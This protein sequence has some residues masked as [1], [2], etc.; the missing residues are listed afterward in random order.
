MI[1]LHQFP[2]AF[3]LINASP[4]CL[5]LE[6]W[7]RLTGLEYRTVPLRDPGEGPKGRAPYIEDG[8][9]RIG[10]SALIIEHLKRS[11]GLD[12]DGRL[13]PTE[14]GIGRAVSLMLEDHL[15][16]II[17]HERW[18]ESC[19][20]PHVRDAFLRGLPDDEAFAIQN[21]IRRRIRGQGLGLHTREERV[22]LGI[23][24][25]EA[26]SEILGSK[27]FLL[28][29]EATTADCTAFAMMHNLL[30]PTFDNPVRDAALGLANIVAYEHR[31][32]QR[33]FPEARALA[34]A[35]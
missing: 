26:L 10:D 28:G 21:E 2:P 1:I 35:A 11:R 22:A 20:W 4:F 27:P 34:A 30:C 23:A 9:E 3:G 8:D 33:L 15:M 17:L 7:L 25:V 19:G 31:M 14:R 32:R 6:S 29:P 12:P 13:G 5:K 18:V 16:F 24:D